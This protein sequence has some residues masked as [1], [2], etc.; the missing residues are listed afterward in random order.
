MQRIEVADLIRGFSLLGIF[1]A[2]LL[3]F[4]YGLTGQEYLDLYGI[5]PFNKFLAYTINIL[6]VGSFLPI[7]AVLFGFS[8]DKLFQSMKRK[9]QR[10]KKTKLFIRAI[11]LITLGVLHSTFIWEG[12]ILLSYGISMLFIILF[13]SLSK[14][15]FKW[16]VILII[17]SFILISAAGL[18][19]PTDDEDLELMAD[20]SEVSSYIFNLKSAY[21]NGDYDEVYQARNNLED[22]SFELLMNQFEG[23]EFL[24][25]VLAFLL[26]I[27]LYIIGIYLSKVDW[28]LKDA[29]HF[30]SSKVFIY[31]IPLC[32][33]AKAAPYY[34]PDTD[35][36]I[37][38]QS[39]FGIIL[40]FGYMALIKWLYQ[41]NSEHMLFIGLKSLGKLSLTIYIIQSIIGTTLFYGYGAGWFGMDNLGMTMIIFLVAFLLQ[42][43]FS[44]WYLTKFRY[45]PLEYILRVL[46]NLKISVKPSTNEH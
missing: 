40:S 13:I 23:A 31:L 45:G 26:A 28:F 2:N 12:D 35:L 21:G 27:P 16:T 38:L 30:W 19:A 17:I 6:F 37:T 42:M 24:I 25:L 34:L 41:K 36:G 43:L 15:F 7:F 1:M 18:F 11:L 46:T 8:M 29:N 32:L 5:S 10:F 44:T 3:I 9:K 14:R 4:Q 20:E 22:P 33:L 39:T